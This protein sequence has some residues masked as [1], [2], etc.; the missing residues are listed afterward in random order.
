[1]ELPEDLLIKVLQN[2]HPRD[3]KVIGAVICANKRLGS[4]LQRSLRFSDTCNLNATM[5]EHQVY[6]RWKTGGW[7]DLV[8]EEELSLSLEDLADIK[9]ITMFT[10][11][12]G[13]VC[14]DA[15]MQRLGLL[16]TRDI[17]YA[18]QSWESLV[19]TLRQAGSFKSIHAAA[20]RDLMKWCSDT[21][22]SERTIKCDNYR[23]ALM[24][25][26]GHDLEELVLPLYLDPII[27][28]K[29]LRPDIMP[30]HPWHGLTHLDFSR[31][32][33]PSDR[34]AD[35]INYDG[36]DERGWDVSLA[37]ILRFLPSLAVFA[38]RNTP[39]GGCSFMALAQG[40]SGSI[41][42]ID[43]TGCTPVG[44]ASAD[45][46][47]DHYVIS[48]GRLTK[49]QSLLLAGTHVAGFF[50]GLA[51]DR[52]AQRVVAGLTA[53]DISDAEIGGIPS[54]AL[55]DM[56]ILLLH[57]T[58]SLR[59]FSAVGLQSMAG[60]E[61]LLLEHLGM[62]STT[63]ALL[64]EDNVQ[65]RS[66]IQPHLGCSL[67]HLSVAWGFDS[68]MLRLFIRGSEFL[69]SL[70]VGLGAQ[71]CDAD[72]AVVSERCPHLQRLEL[73]FVMVSETG[74]C[75]VVRTCRSLIALRLLRCSGPFGDGLG[76]AFRSRRPLL[77]LWE[78][79]IVDGAHELTDRG[80]A[81]C[82]S[83]AC[84]QLHTLE[85]ARCSSLTP[86]ALAC[87]REHAGTLEH[88]SLVD[89]RNIDAAAG[90][91]VLTTLKALPNL[92]SL[93]LRHC[94]AHLPVDPLLGNLLRPC[95]RLR[96]VVL[97]ACDL[98]ATSLQFEKMPFYTWTEALRYVE[99]HCCGK[100]A[101]ENQPIS[102]QG[103]FCGEPQKS[104]GSSQDPKKYKKGIQQ[105]NKS[106]ESIES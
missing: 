75:M 12:Q 32:E 106:N 6:K 24:D 35:K 45:A 23:D 63:N 5:A 52:A 81:G 77:L 86:G 66:E 88:L 44:C 46:R 7:D 30:P 72:L 49:L 70:S 36:I 1:M 98:G 69:T 2:I 61:H 87:I 74:V 27:L 3:S 103:A 39:A 89:C 50:C 34:D 60:S 19:M 42:H 17:V 85:L 99:L 91:D 100:D 93:T 53:L 28:F 90:T 22:P 16:R 105:P 92:L 64:K 71:I 67:L 13:A 47:P 65:S 8:S 29:E 20:A 102:S 80:L 43:L 95:R 26:A 62:R 58:V 84:A 18:M 31:P 14:Y 73:R 56:V 25:L 68:A 9:S 104:D 79:R 101:W 83:T 97:D 78:L 76:A 21:D 94:T 38:A 48:L 57:T 37:G 33:K 11:L 82:L 55:V 41:T 4:L 96:N 59:S 10:D 51:Q 54:A 15:K 40:C